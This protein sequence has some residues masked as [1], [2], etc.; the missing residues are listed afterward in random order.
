MTKYTVDVEMTLRMTVET[1]ADSVTEA[2]ATALMECRVYG[3]MVDWSS[4]VVKGFSKTR[5]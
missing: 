4:N 5:R 3:D 2:Q 1:E